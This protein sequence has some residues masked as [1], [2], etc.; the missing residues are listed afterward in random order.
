MVVRARLGLVNVDV[1]PGAESLN[2][3]ECVQ[4]FLQGFPQRG[5]PGLLGRGRLALGLQLG[6]LGAQRGDL[7]FVAPAENP[8]TGVVA[9]M[10]IVLLVPLA[11]AHLALAGDG[12]PL[13]AELLKACCATEVSSFREFVDEVFAERP[14]LDVDAVGE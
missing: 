8:T 14:V 10:P 11:G 12:P 13:P 2:P 6:K 4:P 1:G 3:K 5:E 9:A 7:P